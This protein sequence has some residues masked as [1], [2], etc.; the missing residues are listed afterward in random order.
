MTWPMMMPSAIPDIDQTA[1]EAT[2][3]PRVGRRYGGRRKRR[4]YRVNDVANDDAVCHPGHRPDGSRPDE[5]AAGRAPI[6]WW[7]TRRTCPGSGAGTAGDA[8][9]LRAR[10]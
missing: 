4:P 5:Q 9:A 7:T 6:R 10:E 3:R 2:N 8:R 1:D